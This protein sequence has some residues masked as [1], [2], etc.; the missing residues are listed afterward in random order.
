MN[1]LRII[2]IQIVL[3]LLISLALSE[4]T[5]AQQ[6]P[7]FSQYM[8]NTMSVNSAYAGTQDAINIIL[9]SRHQWVGFEGAP[10]T[11]TFTIHSPVDKKYIGLGFSYVRDQ[12]GPLNIDNIYLDYSFKI[13]VHEGGMLSMGLKTG[14]DVRKNSLTDLSPLSNDPAYYTD[15]AS[16]VSPNFGIGLYYYTR[17][18]YAGVSVPKIRNTNL[19]EDNFEHL[20][21]ETLERHYFIIGG[22]V[23][24]I[25]PTWKLKPSFFAKHVQG[26]PLS[27][28]LNVSTM[29]NERVVAG[30]SHRFG[31]SFGAMVQ[32]RVYS[33]LWLGYAY[34]FTTTPLRYHNSG[35]HEVM[36][37]FDLYT[38]KK[39]VVKSPRFF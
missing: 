14:I 36:A 6:D 3:A 19:S 34:D 32:V 30:L 21:Q 33:Y 27:F 7:G 12:I 18:Y 17:N 31:D 8:Y 39:E 5:S 1:T 22:Y 28:D 4:K 13:R 9:L 25:N 29:Y 38:P 24:E 35:T 20:G 15:I 16:K 26:A 23:W 37:L 10:S 2:V 11:Q